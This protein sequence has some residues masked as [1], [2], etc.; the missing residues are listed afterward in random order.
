MEKIISNVAEMANETNKLTDSV[1]SDAAVNSVKYASAGK[2]TVTFVSF[3]KS[4][5][6]FL[7]IA[8]NSLAFNVAAISSMECSS[9]CSHG[10]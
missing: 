6:A 9:I 10:E 1:T 5:P 8:T 3:E 4:M 2:K 7:D